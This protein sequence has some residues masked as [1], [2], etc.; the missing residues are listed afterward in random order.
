ESREI[1]DAGR[2]HERRIGKVGVEALLRHAGPQSRNAPGDVAGR[3]FV[4]AP[5]H[6]AS[7]HLLPPVELS[8]SSAKR[9]QPQLFVFR[10]ICATPA[11]TVRLQILY[12]ANRRRSVRVRTSAPSG[13]TISESP[14]TMYPTAG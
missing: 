14:S 10:R 1:M 6:Q 9:G 8:R 5:F 13:R 7:A 3:Q 4:L 12:C 11:G 2:T